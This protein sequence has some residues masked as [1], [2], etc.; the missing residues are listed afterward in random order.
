MPVKIDGPAGRQ[1]VS[2]EY[3]DNYDRTFRGTAVCG[4][5]DPRECQ[6]DR[7]ESCKHC[8]CYPKKSKKDG[9]TN[10]KSSS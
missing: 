2:Q 4:C 5:P 6:V 10:E 3:R 8:T 7:S 1:H 9:G